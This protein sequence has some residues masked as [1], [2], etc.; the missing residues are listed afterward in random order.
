MSGRLPASF[1]LSQPGSLKA[2]WASTD[3]KKADRPRCVMRKDPTSGVPTMVRKCY[4]DSCVAYVFAAQH[5]ACRQNHGPRDL[6]DQHL[7]QADQDVRLGASQLYDWLMQILLR[8]ESAIP[9]LTSELLIAEDQVMQEFGFCPTVPADSVAPDCT[10]EMIDTSVFWDSVI[11]MSSTA[12]LSPW[13]DKT[14]S[15]AKMLQRH[16]TS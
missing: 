8:A 6:I 1:P 3:F 16:K 9:E 7:I 15:Y 4:R 12:A 2:S 13:E 5:T 11:G 10:M 14:S